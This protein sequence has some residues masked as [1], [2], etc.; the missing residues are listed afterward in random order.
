MKSKASV[1]PLFY[2]R[3]KSA[4]LGFLPVLATGHTVTGT[5][6]PPPHPAAQ[7]FVTVTM[8]PAG[9]WPLGPQP[10]ATLVTWITTQ[11]LCPHLPHLEASTCQQK[12]TM[13]AAH[14]LRTQKGA[15]LTTSTH[16]PRP[17]AQTPPEEGPSSSDCLR[18]QDVNTHVVE[19][20]RG[21]GSS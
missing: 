8:R 11:S 2:K 6:L 17:P 10:R 19:I 1:L 20:W 18:S 7:T 5:L 16:R 13:K 4:F 21:G 3:T 12:K 15:T 9:E 14:L